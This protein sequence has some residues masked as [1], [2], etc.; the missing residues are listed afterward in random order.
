MC[1]ASTA[2]RRRKQAAKKY[3]HLAKLGRPIYNVMSREK[4]A[5]KLSRAVQKLADI[6]RRKGLK[7]KK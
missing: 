7:N 1:V 6:A 2:K 4:S 3:R 5:R